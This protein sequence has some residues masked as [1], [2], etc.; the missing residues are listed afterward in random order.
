[1][2]TTQY[3]DAAKKAL[4]IESDYALAPHLDLTTQAISK[5]RTRPLVMSNTTAVKI[6]EI[7]GIDPMR[8][9]ADAELERG[10][11][12]ELWKRIR[13]AAM[14]G[15]S[16]IGAVALARSW[17][18]PDLTVAGFVSQAWLLTAA[19]VPAP[20]GIHIALL[21]SLWTLAVIATA[22]W[23]ARRREVLL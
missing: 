15:L 12:D 23:L 11:N 20:S 19:Y 1:M 13:A 2:K 17:L 9:I 16:V 7:L 8:A 10:T 6:A 21:P 22:L 5:L 14:F 3:L 18:T 4:G